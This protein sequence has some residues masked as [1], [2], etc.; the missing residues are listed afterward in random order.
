LDGTTNAQTASYTFGATVGAVAVDAATGDIYVAQQSLNEVV[1]LDKTMAY[2]GQFSVT[3]PQ[4]ITFAD[5]ELFV[6]SSGNATLSIFTVS[7]AQPANQA[8]TFNAL[9]DLP[10][11]TTPITLAATSD[12]GLPVG[13][14]VISGPATVNGNM[15]TLTG[16]GA[17]T[18]EASQ[19]GNSGY[20]AAVAV[21]RTFNV[22]ADLAS[23]QQSVFTT[24][25][26]ANLS[27]SGP[28]A[29]Y[30]HDGLSN[31]VKYALGLNPKVDAVGSAL[32]ATTTTATDWVYTYKRPT[33][34]T[35]ITYAVQVS[36]D[37]VNWTTTGVTL[38][39]VSSSGVVDT[40]HGRY[41]RASAAK[42]F[43]RLTVTTN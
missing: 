11:T 5:G 8:I 39:L 42:L 19:P 32:P 13:F 35:D 14:A 29:V 9:P 2:V 28:A 40:W 26:L 30:G 15:L 37:L 36:T 43:F 41:P 18:V 12:S 21:D 24:A 3:N 1:R 17:V 4:S 25:E 22:T 23:W 34:I 7:T 6:Q 33:N 16:P 38:E 31:L 27:V 10:F 20:A